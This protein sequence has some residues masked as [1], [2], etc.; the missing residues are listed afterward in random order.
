MALS[1]EANESIDNPVISPSGEIVA[2][3][4]Y[5][6]ATSCVVTPIS[7]ETSSKPIQLVHP[8][9]L[10][11]APGYTSPG[12]TRNTLPQNGV[13]DVGREPVSS[14][15]RM[16]SEEVQLVDQLLERNRHVAYARRQREFVPDYQKDN[17]YWMKRQKNN[18]AAKR[19]REKRRLNDL[20]LET[21][22]VELMNEN[23]QLKKELAALKKHVAVT[24][25]NKNRLPIEV[26]E[27]VI[28]ESPVNSPKE[29]D[30]IMA[31]PKESSSPQSRVD[32]DFRRQYSYADQWM[33]PLLPP[34]LVPSV[35][36]PRLVA[37]R[38]SDGTSRPRNPARRVDQITATSCPVESQHNKCVNVLKNRNVGDEPST[39]MID[40]GQ[41]EVVDLRV[42]I[43]GKESLGSW[44]DKHVANHGRTSHNMPPKIR[45]K[46]DGYSRKLLESDFTVQKSTNF[47][48]PC[49][50][51][52]NDRT[53]DMNF[54]S[55][56]GAGTEKRTCSG[57]KG[58][59]RP[60]EHTAA[61]YM[62]S[63]LQN[64][65]TELPVPLPHSERYLT[66]YVKPFKSYR[67]SPYNHHDEQSNSQWSV[68]ST[69][70]RKEN[71]DLRDQLTGLYRDVALLKEIVTSGT[72]TRQ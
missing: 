72:I 32:V 4:N 60:E 35:T 45:A 3:H 25:A 2:A 14:D 42:N 51:T 39:N 55:L 41:Y 5:N 13:L 56:D 70:L 26:K 31:S 38:I 49:Q 16:Q 66:N 1:K 20:V 69:D 36:P 24:D 23:T 57:L 44:K 21:K 52:L 59:S 67:Y 11:A 6:I 71:V 63:A 53:D 40:D 64:N 48:K 47:S 8:A 15:E 68:H 62:T 30:D 34:T 7:T 65:R 33:N 28:T 54:T 19:S 27:E 61:V 58:Y 37:N 9:F 50:D 29:Q 22:V 18:E 17:S 10:M 12:V 46:Q 43:S